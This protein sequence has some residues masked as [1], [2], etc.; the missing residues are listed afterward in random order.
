MVAQ[1]RSLSKPHSTMAT[2]LPEYNNA[3]EVI[4]SIH[5]FFWE[6]MQPNGGRLPW[7]GGVLDQIEKDFRLF[8]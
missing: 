7:G 8:L 1:W 6:S 4:I 5:D 2:P 3:A